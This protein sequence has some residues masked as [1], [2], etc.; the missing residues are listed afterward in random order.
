V[1]AAVELLVTDEGE[2]FFS[3]SMS[4][5]GQ[6]PVVAKCFPAGG[7]FELGAICDRGRP[8]LGPNSGLRP[9]GVGGRTTTPRSFQLPAWLPSTSIS[10][11]F[12]HGFTNASSS[13]SSGSVMLA[14]TVSIA[15]QWPPQ[16]TSSTPLR[17]L[18]TSSTILSDR[19]I[20]TRARETPVC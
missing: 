6:R 1:V 5:A 20:R 13:N 19:Q 14:W 17:V 4:C 16:Q 3:P 11:P 8:G 10:T 9:V 7:Q 15:T 2:S 12:V 18:W